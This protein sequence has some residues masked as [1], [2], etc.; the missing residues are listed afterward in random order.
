MR[1]TPTILWRKCHYIRRQYH[2]SLLMD[3]GYSLLV[4]ISILGACMCCPSFCLL[5][6]RHFPSRRCE[7]IFFRSGDMKNRSGTSRACA[8]RE[9]QFARMF[10]SCPSWKKLYL[11]TILHHY[12]GLRFF[13]TL[14]GRVFC[15]S[16]SRIRRNKID[17]WKRIVGNGF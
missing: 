15:S 4:S 1:S 2:L 7:F 9:S 16:R 17:L 14:N 8:S 11:Y 6:Q 12:F 13:L 3:R 5:A 10:F